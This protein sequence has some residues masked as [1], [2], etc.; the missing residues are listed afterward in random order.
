MAGREEIPVEELE[1]EI[2]AF[3]ASKA[4][5]AGQA[6][7]R[8]GCNLAHGN[9]C[10][11]A[12]CYDNQPR[13][14][15]LDFFYEGDL[16]IWIIAEPGG[17]LSN[18]QRNDRVSLAIFDKVDHSVDQMSI[19][20][21]GRAEIFKHREH[22]DL[23]ESKVRVFGLDMAIQ[24]MMQKLVANQMLPKEAVDETIKKLRKKT[25]LLKI[26]PDKIAVLQ[27]K[28]EGMAVRKYWEN[29]RAYQKQANF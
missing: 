14:T 7:D 11:L 25:T 10:V 19:Q 18:I 22:P 8:P 9:A 4:T 13:A 27:T 17:K 28:A 29:G 16:E 26:T 20:L 12:T 15:P 2:A 24:G 1:K 5:Q 3:L 21:W 6:S 23:V